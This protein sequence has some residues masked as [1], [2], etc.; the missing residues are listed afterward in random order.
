MEGMYKK[1]HEAIRADPS[2]KPSVREVK[3]KK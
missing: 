2:P 1:T 3:P